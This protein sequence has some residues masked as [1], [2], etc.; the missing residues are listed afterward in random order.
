MSSKEHRAGLNL[1][2]IA[3]YFGAFMILLAYTFFLGLQW[4]SLGGRGQAAAACGTVAGLWGIGALLRRRGYPI[5][6]NLLV[7]AGTG[8]TA[9][10]VYSVLA[11]RWPLARVDRGWGLPR[12]LPDDRRQLGDP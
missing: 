11:A 6:G 8:V 5:A 7:F 3:Y 1:V 2:T 9:L 12:L 10:A 4:E